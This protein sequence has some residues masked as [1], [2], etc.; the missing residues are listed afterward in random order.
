MPI[1]DVQ[2]RVQRAFIVNIEILA[3]CDQ[4]TSDM[5]NYIGD[6]FILCTEVGY[7]LFC[8]TNM[9]IRHILAYKRCS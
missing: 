1:F 3:K 6:V 4:N 8:M 7:K 5:V 9:V 2:N